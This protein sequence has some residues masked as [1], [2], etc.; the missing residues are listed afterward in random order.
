[1]PICAVAALMKRCAFAGTEPLAGVTGP[2]GAGV[3]SL[4]PSKYFESREP[5]SFR[6]VLGPTTPSVP[7]PLAR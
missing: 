6:L 3:K 2:G 1:L 4:L 7:R 5:K